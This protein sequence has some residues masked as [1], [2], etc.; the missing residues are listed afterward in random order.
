MVLIAVLPAPLVFGWRS[1]N[2]IAARR[3]AAEAAVPATVAA[4]ALGAESVDRLVEIPDAAFTG[5]R[6]EVY[7]GILGTDLLRSREYDYF[8]FDDAPE[9]RERIAALESNPTSPAQRMLGSPLLEGVQA[10]FGGRPP[11]FAAA[12]RREAEWDRRERELRELRRAAPNLVLL[13]VNRRLEWADLP[14]TVRGRVRPT[15]TDRDRAMG[16]IRTELREDYPGGWR[17]LVVVE[18]DPPPE[19]TVESWALIL[20]SAVALLLALR[21]TIPGKGSAGIAGDG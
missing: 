13:R 9:R 2:A 11:D 12:E 18:F 7:R 3:A 10:R 8:L 4:R 5:V 14:A 16:G 6:W 21:A 15:P 19:S 20:V 1:L 17:S